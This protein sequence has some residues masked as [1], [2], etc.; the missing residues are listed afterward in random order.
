[1]AKDRYWS[2]VQ[3]VRV[4]LKLTPLHWD[5]EPGE[6]F[7]RCHPTKGFKG[8]YEYVGHRRHQTDPK[9][10]IYTFVAR[11][12]KGEGIWKVKSA[13]RETCEYNFEALKSRRISHPTADPSD[14]T[15]EVS[16]G[17]TP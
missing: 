8:I 17:G 14:D 16:A 15:L 13:A 12:G 9:K 11:D 6:L 10:I 1:M 4:K 7:L 5:I 2:A 3:R